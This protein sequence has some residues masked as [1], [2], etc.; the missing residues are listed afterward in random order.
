MKGTRRAQDS[1][2]QPGHIPGCVLAEGGAHHQPTLVAPSHH[3]E[4]RT[5]G[6]K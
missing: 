1:F 2:T 3:C 6:R 4:V 5:N